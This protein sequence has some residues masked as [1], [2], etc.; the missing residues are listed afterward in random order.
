[1][2]ETAADNV[3]ADELYRW[4]PLGVRQAASLLGRLPAPWWIAGGWAIDLFLGQQSREHGDIDIQ[5]LRRDQLVLQRY[6]NGWELHAAG[7]GQ[8]RPWAPGEALTPSISDI[9][10]RRD[11]TSPWSV[12]FMLADS[13]AD[14]WVFRRNPR[15]TLPLDQFGW[16]TADGLPYIAPQ[17]QLLFK[18][19]GRRAK[20]DDDF[21]RALPLLDAPSRRWLADAI[22]QTHPGHEWLTQLA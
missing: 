5:V 8:L 14:H 9:W 6:F 2:G 7:G 17:V 3:D 12:Q 19:K 22:A 10:G 13:E 1:M 20:D 11:S 18:A 21:A 16:R 4:R 15:V